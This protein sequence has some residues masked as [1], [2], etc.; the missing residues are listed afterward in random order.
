LKEPIY[1]LKKEVQHLQLIGNLTMKWK[2]PPLTS[3]NSY[4]G[5][6]EEFLPGW[7][8]LAHWMRL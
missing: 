6:G 3:W 8:P 7:E 2:F 5:A 4:L 1:Q